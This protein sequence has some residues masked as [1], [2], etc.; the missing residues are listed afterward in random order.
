M[1]EETKCLHNFDDEIPGWKDYIDKCKER[2]RLDNTA[3][4]YD[5]R[6]KSFVEEFG[7]K[8]VFLRNL[9]ICPKPKYLFLCMEPSLPQKGA[10]EIYFSPLFLHYCAWK[11]LC[12]EKF[13]Y[14]I[15][16]L[17]KGC[18]ENQHASKS[19]RVRWPE[20][21]ELFKMEL[22]LLKPEKIIL[23]G[24]E[25]HKRI[26]AFPQI[27]EKLSSANYI[28]H[29]GRAHITRRNRE[30]IGFKNME[31]GDFKMDSPPKEADFAKEL[32]DFAKKLKEHINPE[33]CKITDSYYEEL[34]NYSLSEIERKLFVLYKYDFEHLKKTGK[35]PHL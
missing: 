21:I 25:F 32:R 23:I 28:A 16:N 22:K 2:V 34:I 31:D 24:S 29:Y 9:E 6:T 5:K 26:Q 1:T 14:Y 18:M 13:N 7:F 35:I 8:S 4:L 11:Y 20:W 19:A 30:Y 10:K 15:S 33:R 3:K 27:P 17:A 12:G